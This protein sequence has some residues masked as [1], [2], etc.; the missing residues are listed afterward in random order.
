MVPN[1]PKWSTK[2]INHK[3]NRMAFITRFNLVLVWS[4]IVQILNK[5]SS[6]WVRHNQVS[7]SSFLF[8]LFHTESL[9]GLV[10]PHL[11]PFLILDMLPLERSV[12]K[13]IVL[14][15]LLKNESWNKYLML[16]VAGQYPNSGRCYF[17]SLDGA[18]YFKY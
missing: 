4:K 13:K 16:R 3:F 15:A 1:G 2:K 8:T 14:I 6:N 12:L 5:K 18:A 7:W 17:L 11:Q 10:G 9:I